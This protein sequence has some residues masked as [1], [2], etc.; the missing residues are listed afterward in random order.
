M[1]L[2]NEEKK[3]KEEKNDNA[4]EGSPGAF[5]FLWEEKMKRG[6]GYACIPKQPQRTGDRLSTMMAE[7]EIFGYKIVGSSMDVSRHWWHRPGLRIMLRQARK[8]KLDYIYIDE[9][10][11]SYRNDFREKL[12]KK[13]ARY[14]VKVYAIPFDPIDRLQRLQNVMHFL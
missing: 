9:E 12:T 2:R 13:L 1:H 11:L 3:S 6:W 14:G 10:S 4:A 5:R 7:A 8:G